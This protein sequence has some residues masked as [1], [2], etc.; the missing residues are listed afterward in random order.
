MAERP[1][2]RRRGGF[3]EVA[4]PVP[5]AGRHYD[6]ALWPLWEA[7]YRYVIALNERLAHG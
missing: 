1:R 6:K 2:I 7:A 5:C 3:W 4:F